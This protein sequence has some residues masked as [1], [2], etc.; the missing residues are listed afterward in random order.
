MFQKVLLFIII[1]FSLSQGVCMTQSERII[2]VFKNLRADRISILDDFYD[3]NILFKDPLGEHR[4]L[5]AMKEYYRKLYRN[6]QSIEFV[7]KDIIS[8]G[9]K[10]V[11]VWQMRLRARGLNGGKLVV[12]DGNSVIEFNERNLVSYHRDYFDMNEFMYQY[13]PVLGWLTQKVNKELKK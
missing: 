4:G 10:H 13:I 7:P 3:P 8:S 6:V 2:D 9:N 1:F 5:D 11:Y 12:V